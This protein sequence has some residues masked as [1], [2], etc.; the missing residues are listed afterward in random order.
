MEQDKD[1]T[2]ATAGV[3]DV[4]ACAARVNAQVRVVAG[5]VVAQRRSAEVAV[6]YVTALSAGTRAGCW[7]LAEADGHESWGR[8][9]ALLGS[10]AWDWK[11]LRAELAGL[12]AAWLPEREGDLIE[13]GIAID[14]T[15]P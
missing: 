8:M 6:A 11:D 4:A 1:D 15:A 13:P 14:E 9:Q 5:K 2:A 3:K 10:Y 7:S 12:A